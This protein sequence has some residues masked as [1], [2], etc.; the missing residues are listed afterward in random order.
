MFRSFLTCLVVLALASNHVT[1]FQVTSSNVVAGARPTMTQQASVP[2]FEKSSTALNL[3]VK[4]DP[5]AAKSDRTNPAVFK[6]ALYLGSVAFAVL[7]PLIFLLA[8]K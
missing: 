5:E 2:L 8:A 7:L 3:K 4:I 6:N 1:A